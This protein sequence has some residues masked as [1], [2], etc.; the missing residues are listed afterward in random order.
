MKDS[1]LRVGV[2]VGMKSGGVAGTT[3]WLK[4]KATP[5]K[6]S[7]SRIRHGLERRFGR[8]V[9]LHL[10]PRKYINSSYLVKKASSRQGVALLYEA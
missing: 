7:S 8:R 4:Y 10:F 9:M 2:G 3:T 6:A 5:I 1:G